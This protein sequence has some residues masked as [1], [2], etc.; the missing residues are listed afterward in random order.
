MTN[1]IPE[2]VDRETGCGAVT[3]VLFGGIAAPELPG[4]KK[5]ALASG[6]CRCYSGFQLDEAHIRNP[7]S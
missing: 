1:S 7:V 3:P 6:E 4:E 5:P 2:D